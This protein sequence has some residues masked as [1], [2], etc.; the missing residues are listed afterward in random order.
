MIEC[1]YQFG[2]IF[3]LRRK[4]SFFVLG[5]Y[6]LFG[7]WSGLKV[8]SNLFWVIA[9]E[10]YSWNLKGIGLFS[11]SLSDF[12]FWAFVKAFG[13]SFCWWWDLEIRFNP[14]IRL[15]KPKLSMDLRKRRLVL[16]MQGER[17]DIPPLMEN[18]GILLTLG[19]N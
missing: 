6:G 12:V 17:L 7:N 1:D 3:E 9:M 4:K 8:F 5:F 13:H 10:G 15:R 16:E 2:I 19:P 11:I 14:T 18:H